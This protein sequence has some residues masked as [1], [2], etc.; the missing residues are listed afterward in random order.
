M[1]KLS[2]LFSLIRYGAMRENRNV[3][4]AVF[5]LWG[6]NSAALSREVPNLVAFGDSLTQGYGLMAGDGLVPQLQNWLIAHETQVNIINAGVSG[7][8]TAGGLGRIDWTLTEDVSAIMIILGGNDLL[9]GLSPAISRANLDGIITKARAKG[10]PVL[11]VPMAAPANYGPAY[12]AEFDAIFPALAAA[13]EIT[14]ATPLLA[15]LQGQGFA[16][17]LRHFMQTDSIHPNP[18]GVAQII[19]VL[20]PQ[21]A[22]WLSQR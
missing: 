20:G 11:L 2:T 18:K 15:P 16:Y 10:A 22:A 1:N 21:V 12:Q 4:L 7:D 9:R 6:L 14:L 17:A 3:I 8:T 5:F 13:H 19:K